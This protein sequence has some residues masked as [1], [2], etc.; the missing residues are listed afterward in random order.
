MAVN[1]NTSKPDNDLNYIQKTHSYFR[2]NTDQVHYK[3]QLMM[4]REIIRAYHVNLTKHEYTVWKK[5]G[6]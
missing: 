3:K 4:H 5:C 2:E 6:F 1:I